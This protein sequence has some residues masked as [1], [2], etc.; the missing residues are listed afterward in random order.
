MIYG[1]DSRFWNGI[2]PEGYDFRFYMAKATQGEWTSPDF[3]I[4]YRAA[5]QLGLMRSPFCFHRHANDAL[6]SAKWFHNAVMANGGYGKIPPVLDCEDTKA[7]RNDGLAE[8]I[9]IQLQEMEQLAGLEVMIYT[10]AWYWDYF[11]KDYVKDHQKFYDRLLWEAD[12]PP[13]T[14]EPGEWTKDKL[15][16]VQIQLGWNAPGFNTDIDV[17]EITDEQYK[18]W[19]GEEPETFIIKDDIP[20]SAG[21]IVVELTR[22]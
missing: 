20:A 12:P 3:P 21:K 4:Q 2:M 1:F 8:H 15:V 22:K 17:D 18:K 10:A 13:E 9:W 14:P 6:K 19:L 7:H 5:E 16:M 11:V